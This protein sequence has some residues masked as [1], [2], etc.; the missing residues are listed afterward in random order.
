MAGRP[1]AVAAGRL[2]PLLRPDSPGASPA[3]RIHHVG[4]T[5]VLMCDS[6]IPGRDDGL[7][8]TETLDRIDTRLAGLPRDPRR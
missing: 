6:T 1:G 5:A 2:A 7:L 3:D 4:G 8:D